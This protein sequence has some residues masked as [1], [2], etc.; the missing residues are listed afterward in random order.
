MSLSPHDHI[1]ALLRLAD[2]CWRDFDSRRT[3]EW[4]VNFGLW[5]GQALFAGLALRADT[6]FSIT[7]WRIVEFSLILFFIVIVYSAVWS[8]GL[9]RRNRENMGDAHHY[10]DLAEQIL[11]TQSTRLRRAV[12]KKPYLLNWA[13]ASQVLITLLFTLLDFWCVWVRAT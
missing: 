6:K 1:D 3:Y 12:P 13:V 4:K 9:R 11:G 7:G 5:T 8:R 2:A 10:W